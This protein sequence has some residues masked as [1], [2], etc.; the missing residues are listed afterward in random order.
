MNFEQKSLASIM[1]ASIPAICFV[2]V[3]MLIQPAQV[4]AQWN[5][6]PAIGAG[7]EYD[8]NPGLGRITLDESSAKGYLLEV[9]AE[10]TYTS[11]ISDFSILPRV[12]ARQ[13]DDQSELDSDDYY[14]DFDYIYTGQRSN[15]R[16]RGDF[17]DESTRTA[18]RS[19]VDFDIDDPAEIPADDTA[20][21]LTTEDRQRLRVNPRWSYETTQRTLL[22][23]DVNHIDVSY[24]EGNL[25][26]FTDYEETAGRAFFEFS[27]TPRNTLSIG[28]YYRSNSFEVTDNDLSG[29]GVL[30]G[31]R[32]LVSQNARF[33]INVG[34]DSTQIDTGDRESNTIGEI[35]FVRNMETSRVVAAYRRTLTGGGA[36]YMSL[37]DTVQLSFLRDISEKFSFGAGIRAYETQAVDPNIVGIDDREWLQFRALFAW[38]PTRRFAIELDYSYTEI[39]RDLLPSAQDSN[40]VNLWFRY[41]SIRRSD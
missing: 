4:L 41:R 38:R 23:F 8:D 9:D 13:Y 10:I 40:L 12:L 21:L 37:R 36:G 22:R 18:E 30:I 32:W 39:D 29:R 34:V 20:R 17:S 26:P 25:Q 1:A 33:T 6:A 3:S 35:S 11:Q 24:E 28:G 14:V 15:F 7:L 27:R 31:S 19:D 16:V 5:F 2:F